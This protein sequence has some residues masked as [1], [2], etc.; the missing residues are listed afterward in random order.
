MNEQKPKIFISI[1]NQGFIKTELAT[2]LIKWCKEA[3][4]PLYLDMP[5]SKPIAHNRNTI[6][7]NFLASD[8]EY[9][10]Q[11]DDDNVP[12][13][14]PFNLVDVMI[15]NNI[16]ILSCPVWIYQHKL[17][18]NIYR[19]DEKQEYLIPVDQKKEYGLIEV[20][21]TGTGII[22]CSRNALER[23]ERPFE[24]LFDEYGMESLGLDL[25]FSQKAKKAG[26]KIYS[27]LDYISK[28]YKNIDLSEFINKQ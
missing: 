18:L 2:A 27:H 21:A 3:R 11:I 22:L 5:S 8:A 9:L 16:D 26:F 23:L 20:D 4:Y 25:A 7:K 12:P 24:R 14:S 1:L 6:V 15:N 10:I 28:H 13:K 17:I 19:Y